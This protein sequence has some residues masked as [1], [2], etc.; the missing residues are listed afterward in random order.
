LRAETAGVCSGAASASVAGVAA[1]WLNPLTASCI[2]CR[3][4]GTSSIEVLV[5]GFDSHAMV[6][7]VA[8]STASVSDCC[9]VI[10][11]FLKKN[12]MEAHAVRV[13]SKSAL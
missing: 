8:S 6:S 1:V 9:S 2:L 13:K 5:F 11:F 10:G 4:A 7:S 12:S 3:K